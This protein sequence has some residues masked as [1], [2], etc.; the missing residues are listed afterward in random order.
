MTEVQ[1]NGKD[2]NLTIYQKVI[3]LEIATL[4]FMVTI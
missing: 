2:W 4:L 3:H 1:S